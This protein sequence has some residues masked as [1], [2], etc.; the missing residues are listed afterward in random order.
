MDIKQIQE[1][2]RKAIIL[3]NNPEAK[4][5]EEALEMELK[6]GCI[7]MDILHQFFGKS[8]PTPMELIYDTGDESYYFTH[9]RANPVIQFEKEEIVNRERFKI[10]GKPLDLS[11]VLIAASNLEA[12]YYPD[13][14]GLRVGI[15]NH[16]KDEKKEF[17]VM[18]DLTKPTL[19]EQTEETQ[20]SIAKLLGYD[21]Q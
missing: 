8:D 3:A 11:R 16:D 17:M 1:H 20:L 19:E 6:F 13:S 15:F 2:N 18:W 10:I 14:N 21:K 7:V 5:Y 12:T 9:Y 4:D